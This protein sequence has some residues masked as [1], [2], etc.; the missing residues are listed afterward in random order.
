MSLVSKCSI[1]K[2]RSLSYKCK[3]CNAISLKYWP[4]LP[5][6]SSSHCHCWVR[7]YAYS[8][9]YRSTK[10]QWRFLSSFSFWIINI[11]NRIL[12]EAF[13]EQ[14]YIPCFPKHMR[15]KTDNIWGFNNNNTRK[16]IFYCLLG[17]CDLHYVYKDLHVL[18]F[19]WFSPNKYFFC[20]HIMRLSFLG[21]NS[22]ST[23]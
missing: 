19:L 8:N 6:S 15:E 5:A 11:K 12:L 3:Q 22:T 10:P 9:R 2:T 4:P 17:P 14:P 20:F 21:E 18:M 13:T 16:K 7:S 23:I 1:N